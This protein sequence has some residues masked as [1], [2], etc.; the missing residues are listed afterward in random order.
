MPIQGRLEVFYN[1]T[2]GTVCDDGFTSLEAKV[3]C[4]MLRFTGNLFAAAAL[5]SAAY[6]QG[7]GPIWLDDVACN[8]T[9]SYLSNCRTR[10][11]GEHNCGHNEDVGVDCRR[12]C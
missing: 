2:W 12:T 5:N 4:R 1:N 3:V 7:T 11:W 10:N 8:G 9:E 6:G